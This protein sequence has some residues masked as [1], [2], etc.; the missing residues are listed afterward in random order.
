MG[1]QSY[2]TEPS[3]CGIRCI[4]GLTASNTVELS[5]DHLSFQELLVGCVK[6]PPTCEKMN[7]RTPFMGIHLKELKREVERHMYTRVVNSII[8]NNQKLETS[9]VSINR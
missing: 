7:L 4:S 6:N 1:V 2:R 5:D 3:T 8:Q 9:Q